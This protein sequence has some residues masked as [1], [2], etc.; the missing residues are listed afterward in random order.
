M[1]AARFG[2]HFRVFAIWVILEV[3]ASIVRNPERRVRFGSAE[4]D[5]ERFW[6][7][8]YLALE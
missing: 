1:I 8:G 5:G 7:G 2:H 4:K 6:E 3:L